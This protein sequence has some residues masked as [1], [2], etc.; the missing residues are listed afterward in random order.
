MMAKS[1]D[2]MHINKFMAVSKEN[3]YIT[4]IFIP[5]SELVYQL[6]IS[7]RHKF[8][9]ICTFN[10][11]IN[12]GCCII[13]MYNVSLVHFIQNEM[14]GTSNR[15]FPNLLSDHKTMVPSQE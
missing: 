14:Q 5:A 10:L 3:R 6:S 4:V 1:T 8:S 7:N 12:N 2:A 15:G 13:I 9:V 11:F